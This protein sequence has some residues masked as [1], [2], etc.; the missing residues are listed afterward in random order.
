MYS[1]FFF[2]F[3]IKELFHVNFESVSLIKQLLNKIYLYFTS[4]IMLFI[5]F[6][7]IG[8]A[9]KAEYLYLNLKRKPSEDSCHGEGETF[10]WEFLFLR[11][12][13]FLNSYES[14]S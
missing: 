5:A 8:M 9:L 6:S 10:L 4:F 11:N 3:L 12:T 1:F 7:K 13:Q 14:S 2:Y